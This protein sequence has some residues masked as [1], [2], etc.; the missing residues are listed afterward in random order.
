[1]TMTM[2][3]LNG[4]PSI[5]IAAAGLLLV[6]LVGWFGFV[7][8]QRSKA[9]ELAVTISATERQLAIT[10][11]V[12]RGSGLAQSAKDL[13]VLRTAI[14]D[15]TSMP[16]ILRQL[17]RAA[18]DSNV[19]INGITPG[20]P[21]ASGVA[22]TIP[23]SLTLEGT[24]FGIRVFLGHLRTRADLKGET[25]RASGRLYSVESIQFTGGSDTSDKIAATVTLSAY[26]FN[27]PAPTATPGAATT[28][29]TVPP[30][31]A[32]GG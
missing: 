31:E 10:E 28:V 4:R 17:T 12:A 6:L 32:V 14:P 9:N 25:L 22:N 18:A 13:A 27:T 2:E 5:A 19:A 3:R 24:Y 21:V 26:A 8:P 30:A 23:L 16:Q 15:E 29:T 7:S 11:A 20:S 1:M